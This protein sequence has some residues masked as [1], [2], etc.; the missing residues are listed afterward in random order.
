MLAAVLRQVFGGALV[1]HFA[2]LLLPAQGAQ[3]AAVGAP[4]KL[5]LS[6]CTAT[7]IGCWADCLG[8]AGSET[9][10][11]TL[12]IGV[13]GCCQEDQDPPGKC[14]SCMTACVNPAYAKAPGFV[15]DSCP[16]GSGPEHCPT[17]NPNQMTQGTCGDY[18]AGMGYSIAGAEYGT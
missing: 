16:T 15:E 3:H 14:P 10:S 1:V 12:P 9:D 18:C 4:F 11:R 13:H 7:P 2:H 5:P 6:G 8:A 17:C